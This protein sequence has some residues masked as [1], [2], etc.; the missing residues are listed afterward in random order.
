VPIV[1]RKNEKGGVCNGAVVGW[2]LPLH[3]G[4]AAL[5]RCLRPGVG[6]VGK[7]GLLWQGKDMQG[8]RAGILI[9]REQQGKSKGNEVSR[10]Q[11]CVC[12]VWL[13]LREIGVGGW[14]GVNGEGVLAE[15]DVCVGH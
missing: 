12:V 15:F 11:L 4:D 7:T 2:Q 1:I 5:S 8:Q 10:F 14:V 3:P 6:W 13:P 9:T